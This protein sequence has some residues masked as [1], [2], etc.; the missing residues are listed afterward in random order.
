MASSSAPVSHLSNP[1]VTPLQ[2]SSSSSQIDGIPADLEASIRFAG[3]R[4][5]QAAGVSLRLPQDVVAQAIV[6]YSRFWVSECGSLRMFGAKD[7]SAACLY[8]IAKLSSYPQ[9]PRSILN[10]YAF[11]LSPA[12]PLSG[13]RIRDVPCETNP[14][15]PIS[16]YLS[17]G[18][19]FTQRTC[20]LRTEAQVLRVLGFQTHV[21]LPY[22]LAINYLQALDVF[23][24]DS[25][26]GLAQRTFAHLTSALM[27][28]QLLYL[29]HQPP[30]LATAAIYLAAREMGMRLP[31]E[32]WWEV[33][34]VDR[35]ELGF[36]VVALK[37]MEGFA[38]SEQDKWQRKEVPMTVGDVEGE[39][40]A[41]RLLGGEG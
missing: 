26:S 41:R 29:T 36:L 5:T 23:G 28:P 3:A 22:T 9:S 12:S 24:G 13:G 6:L 34:D 32:D 16:Y 27:S 15:D 30:A 21:A 14:P 1:L 11:L 33:F 2:L 10:V 35:E 39:L 7:I 19:Y 37:S 40:E 8:L 31:A 25:G 18:T 4:L 38:R 17:E 20:L